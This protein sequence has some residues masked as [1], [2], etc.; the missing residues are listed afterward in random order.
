MCLAPCPTFGDGKFLGLL[1][2]R[3]QPAQQGD[4]LASDLLPGFQRAHPD[5]RGPQ[6]SGQLGP[7]AVG[8]MP[9]DVVVAMKAGSFETSAIAE[10][11]R[12]TTASGVSL[13]AHTPYHELKLKSFNPTSAE[14]GMLGASCVRS[15]DVTNRPR[16][17]P[18]VAIGSVTVH[19]SMKSCTL[20]AIR[21]V[22][23]GAV[24]L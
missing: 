6:R 3:K 22:L 11:S 14:V 12:S 24:P 20:P 19:G 7:R 15:F 21:S 13:G 10:A 16:A 23:A 5:Q 1:F 9:S 18:D 4:D 8:T 17:L 2:R